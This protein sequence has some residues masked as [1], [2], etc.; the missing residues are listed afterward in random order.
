MKMCSDQSWVVAGLLLLTSL[1]PGCGESA[2]QANAELIGTVTL[3]GA[4]VSEG[5]IQ[6]ASLKTGSSI[7]G[8][9]SPEGKFLLAL[10]QADIGTEYEVTVGQPIANDQNAAAIAEKPV[11]KKRSLLP[12][13]YA[14]RATSGLKAKVVKAGVNE[15]NFDL[16]SK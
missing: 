9:L 4:P 8:N 16:H 5:S 3:D 13:K 11:E 15:F 12:E 6:F 2:R 1:L 14:D 10:P 7:S